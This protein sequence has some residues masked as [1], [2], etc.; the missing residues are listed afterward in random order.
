[1]KKQLLFILLLSS[2]VSFGQATLIKDINLGNGSSNPNYKI[3]FKNHVYFVAN[4]GLRGSELWRTDG[5]EAGTILFKEFIAGEDSGFSIFKFYA[6]VNLLYFVAKE[7]TDNYLWKTDGTENGTEKIKQ[8]STVTDFHTVINNELI[9]S[10]NNQLWK[11]DGTENGT[12]KIENFPVFG[13]RFVKS[14]S[15]MYFSGESSSSIGRELYKT[16]GSENGAVLIKDI[17]SGS[18]DSFP[19]HFTELNGVIYF[20]ANNGSNGTELW[21]TD[22]SENGT[23]MVKDVASGSSSGIAFN[24]SFVTFNNILFFNSGTSLWASNGIEASTVE[25]K[26]NLGNISLMTTLGNKILIIA[27]DS[28][29]QKQVV[30][31]SD[32]TDNGTTSFEPSY[33]EFAHNSSFTA[34]GSTL[35]FQGRNHLGYEFWKTDGTE[36]GTVLVK[37]IHPEF[38]DNNIE[39]IVALGNN[40]IFTAN[41]GNWKGKELYISDGT[42]NG[43]L[44]LKDIN[45]QGNNS[46]LPQHH[47]QFGDKVLFSADD[48]VHGRELWV[49]EN[50]TTSMVKDINPGPYYGNPSDF[51]ELNGQVYFKAKTSD[52]GIELWKT[53]GTASGTTLVKDI[54]TGSSS[55]LQNSNSANIVVLNNKLYFFATNEITGSEIWESDGTET[56]TKLLK[57]IN[58]GANNSMRS[59]ELIVFKNKLYF[60]ATDSSNDFELWTSDGTEAGTNLF[61]E[62]N[63]S[64]SGSP[65]SFIEFKDGLHFRAN[66]SSGS[67]MFRTDGTNTSTITDKGYSNMT[68]SGEFLYFVSTYSSGGELWATENGV[69][70]YQVKDI[71]PGSGGNNGSFPS[72]LKDHKGTLYFIANDG[73]NGN[74][75]WKSNGTDAGTILVKDIN[76]GS[77]SLTISDMVSFGD[78]LLFG[79]GVSNTSIELW[80]TD[81]TNEDTKLVQEINPSTEQFNSG[82]SPTNFFVSND[83]LYF[84]A[85]DGTVGSELWMLEKTALS[86]NTNSLKNIESVQIYP[87]PTSSFINIKA[88]N[89]SVKRVKIFNILGKEVFK[90]SN[91][92]DEITQI[93]ISQFPSGLYMVQFETE[94]STISKKIIKK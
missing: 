31:V 15:E 18:S 59:G 87:N 21:K 71:R 35:Y 60:N 49:I 45:K 9:F 81:G 42:E 76:S 26:N 48:G 82:S 16:D 68:V 39:D 64:S 63:S 10:A 2:L 57:D 53:D 85:N 12:I 46:S 20:S 66:T 77:S 13:N 70:V 30:W 38:D 58:S 44:L 55:G 86:T 34:I 7:G 14:G 80:L 32:G 89:N 36:N 51:V 65:D 3:T 62:A 67:K 6:D 83:I 75:L 84:S 72:K 33:E 94:T 40:I 61:Y 91:K 78:D 22:G 23:V 93:D 54:Y 52:D 4:D 28:S 1:M 92:K 5:T 79:G 74:E 56:G 90:I 27:R 17:R 47:F 29:T 69:T 50:G 11:T 19:N 37:D 25:V 43:T 24:T 73:T 41:D 8:F 88:N